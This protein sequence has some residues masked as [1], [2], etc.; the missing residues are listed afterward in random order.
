MALLIKQ[1]N[2]FILREPA[3]DYSGG[4][5][6][7]ISLKIEHGLAFISMISMLFESI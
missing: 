1:I 6:F 7:S 3:D 4:L 5:S 2:L